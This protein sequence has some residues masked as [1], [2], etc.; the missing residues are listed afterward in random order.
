M[1]GL[2]GYL[3]LAMVLFMW[4]PRSL[5]FPHYWCQIYVICLAS[6]SLVGEWIDFNAE[7]YDPQEI[8][9]LLVIRSQC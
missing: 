5:Y 1:H 7:A 6:L 4:H 8:V 9:R 3:R 2:R